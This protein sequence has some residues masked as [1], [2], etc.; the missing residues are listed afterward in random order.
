MSPRLKLPPKVEKGR[1]KQLLV[2]IE[3]PYKPMWDGYAAHGPIFRLQVLGQPEWIIAGDPALTRALFKMSADELHGDSDA[4]RSFLGPET[5]LF[6]NDEAHRR[7]R[8][9]L[10]PPFKHQRLGVYAGTMVEKMDARLD[11]LA[12]GDITT[13]QS[14]VVDVSL[15]TIV[16]CIFGVADPRRS[17][18]LS[19]L[20]KEWMHTVQHPAFFF[21]SMSMGGDTVKRA[22][23][24]LVSFSRAKYRPDDPALPKN[25]IKRLAD[26][27][28]EIDLI[29]YEE[30][31]RARAEAG[32]DREDVL[33]MLVRTR[34]DDGS[35]LTDD[36][37]FDQLVT[38]LVG[39]H[40][41]TS[42]SMSWVVYYLLRHPSWMERVQD[43]VASVLGE[44]APTFEDA[45]R[46]PIV[47][48]AIDES[49]R[50]RPVAANVP[51][52]LT[53]PMKFGGY[54]LPK[55]S[56]VFPSPSVLHF[57]EDLWP[58]PHRYDPQRFLDKK[59]SSFEYFPFGGGSR[60]CLGK[61]FAVLQ[62][63]LLTMRLVQR[64]TMR[65]APGC[66]PKPA[67]LGILTGPSDG[68]PVLFEAVR[69]A[70]AASGESADVEIAVGS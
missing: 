25:P 69:P 11:A 33:A 3:C 40:E 26:V 17:A 42:M 22:V 13:I 2:L 35:P 70:G 21:A 53:Q 37:V 6:K 41:T 60:S 55:G 15:G 8:R 10:T 48:A 29:L 63:R 57:R 28:R 52:V 43:E 68:V 44:R 59:P 62:M 46:V 23:R 54:D 67:A 47:S 45:Q 38:F 64:A 18:R 51:R 65:L 7:A 30:I 49:M 20:F 36:D 31:A 24:A 34:Y 16:E 58:E 19:R 5:I 66:D 56:R 32:S 4:L 39:G 9:V 12:P 1:L 27:C 61:P 50:L 14:L